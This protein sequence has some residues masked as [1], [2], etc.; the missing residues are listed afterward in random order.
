VDKAQQELDP[1]AAQLWISVHVSRVPLTPNQ[2][3]RLVRLTSAPTAPV[4]NALPR[5]RAAVRTRPGSL[6]RRTPDD[7]EAA[8]ARDVRLIEPRST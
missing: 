1:I 2:L 8:D 5:R 3:E 6:L 7:R 4:G